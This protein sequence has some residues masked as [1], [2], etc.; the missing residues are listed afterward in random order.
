[1]IIVYSRNKVPI[2]L[3][4][5]RWEHVARRH[6]EMD[7]QKEKVSETIS[8]PDA[9]QKG[10]F[11]E[12][13]ASKLYWVTPHTKKYLV[14]AY[15]EISKQDGFVLTAYFTNSPSTRRQIIWKR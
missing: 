5:E 3:T 15:K 9:I 12:F 6:P 7:A 1:M 13:L 11:G 10:D 8:N 14:V 2:R 4:Q